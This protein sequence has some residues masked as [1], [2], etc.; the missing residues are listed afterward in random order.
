MPFNAGETIGPYR[1]MEQLGQGGMATVYKAYHAALDRYVALKVLHPAFGEDP[2]FEARFKREAR[3]VAKLDHP[4]IVPIYDYSEHDNR[5]F[6]VMK[7]IE[8][9]TLKARMARGPLT[10]VE[11]T[12]IIEAVGAALS[13]AHK[14]G[15]LHRDIKPS[16]ILLTNEGT[17][18]LADFG[19]A[20]I[21]SMGESTL[22]G[23]MI[24]GTPQYISPEQAIGKKNLDEGADIYSFGV[25]LYELVVGQVPF[26]A[27]TP[28]SIIHD[29]IYTPLPIPRAINP[30]IPEAVERVL[31]KSLSKERAD[32]YASVA[33]MVT[34]FKQAWLTAGIPIQGTTITLPPHP[35]AGS[36]SDASPTPK[37]ERP[38]APVVAAPAQTSKAKR[39]RWMWIAGGLLL[40]VCCAFTFL[41]FRR[42]GFFPNRDNPTAVVPPAETVAAQTP[43]P[44]EEP[45]TPIMPPPNSLRILDGF[46]G[47]PPEG[48]AGWDAFFDEATSSKI[49]C[50]PTTEFAHKGGH[51][52]AIQF[53]VPEQGWATCGF[54]FEEVQD[55]GASQGISFFLRADRAG[56]PY[57]V[58]VY[59][60]SPEKRTTYHI[61]LSTPAGSEADWMPVM[62]RWNEILRAEWE[63]N[64]G[65][66]FPPAQVTGF[67]IGISDTVGGAVGGALWLD[68][69][70]LAVAPGGQAPGQQPLPSS[71]L[72]ARQAATQSPTDPYAALNLSLAYWDNNQPREAY[73]AL[74][75]SADLAGSD[76]EF[77]FKASQEYMQR[78]AWV[79][80]AEILLRVILQ[81]D[82][83][84]SPEL[85]NSFHEALYKSA[86][87]PDFK[88]VLNTDDLMRADEPM[89]L[90]AQARFELR[91]NS[92]PERA[93][94]LFSAAQGLRSDMPELI[95]LE[96]EI[97]FKENRRP[98][99]R[100]ILTGLLDKQDL[101]Q[102]IRLMAENLLQKLP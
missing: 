25:V 10:T 37:A 11:L 36:A 47:A 2:N 97:L 24:M 68:D 9:E 49:N 32:R 7:F 15:I 21:A 82:G 40:F 29:H 90:V 33:E 6:L 38:P 102:W 80:V 73:E 44:I 31:L 58:A 43:A 13:Y 86:D 23:D 96:A 87:R 61:R 63:E 3:L 54:Y 76:R 64:P 8:G 95:L 62:I 85:Q 48:A 94:E 74:E 59:G 19:L 51:S 56:L 91:V 20:R 89:A 98:E 92:N 39:P 69:L 22:S 42:G 28:F 100:Q 75:Q 50:A 83:N 65:V 57:D 14:M 60:G 55:W 18:Y 66:P 52:L 46:E 35:A 17:I 72:E 81:E 26:N 34:A 70:S 12:G 1:V 99:A 71:I 16:N 5:P 45:Q 53:E 93:R 41:A 84:P 30:N 4:N 101:P 88:L 79:A 77:F 27:D 78:E 67:S